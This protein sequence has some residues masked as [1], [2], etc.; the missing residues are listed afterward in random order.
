MFINIQDNVIVNLN[1]VCVI[2]KRMSNA[3]SILEVV[4]D[5]DKYEVKPAYIEDFMKKVDS[6]KNNK[7]VTQFF[8]G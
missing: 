6:A 1:D 4:V 8:A 7:L 5:G 2:K 3:K